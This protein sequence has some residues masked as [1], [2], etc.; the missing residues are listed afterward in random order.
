MKFRIERSSNV[1]NTEPPTRYAVFAGED[2]YGKQ[3]TIEIN[4]LEE[5]IDFVKE[6]GK[7]IISSPSEIMPG[8][9]IYDDYRE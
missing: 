6:E 9:E 8:I 7:I 1:L 4:S 5:L 2:K 3:Y